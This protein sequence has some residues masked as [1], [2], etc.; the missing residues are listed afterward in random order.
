MQFNPV[1]CQKLSWTLNFHFLNVYWPHTKISHALMVW[2]C[3]AMGFNMAC[4]SFNFLMT[5]SHSTQYKTHM[6]GPHMCMW[7]SGS[8]ELSGVD[9]LLIIHQW[10]TGHS[11]HMS[12]FSLMTCSWP[13]LPGFDLWNRLLSSLDSDLYKNCAVVNKLCVIITHHLQI[14]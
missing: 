2:S 7:M 11:H 14:M 4:N 6:T 1:L 13:T 5:W 9:G 10:G 12:T 3:L 8:G